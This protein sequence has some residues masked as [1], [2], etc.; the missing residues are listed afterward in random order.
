MPDFSKQFQLEMDASDYNYGTILSQQLDD[1]HWLP[2]AYMSK[3]ML[4]AEHNYVIYDK[5][6]LAI[7]EA[8]K[9]WRHY[10]EGSPH[11]LRFGPITGTLN[12]FGQ[13]NL[14]IATKPN[15]AYS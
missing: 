4:L 12:I 7:I 2:V 13:C 11:P 6:L 15:G 3:Q 5:E 9:L 14:L 8:L 10:L 1:R